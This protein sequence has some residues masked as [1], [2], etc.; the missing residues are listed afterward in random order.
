MLLLAPQQH[1]PVVHTQDLVSK[2]LDQQLAENIQVY[3]EYDDDH[4]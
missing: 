2:I 1:F 3:N 4:I